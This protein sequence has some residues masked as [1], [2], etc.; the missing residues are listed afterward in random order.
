MLPGM[1]TSG[2]FFFSLEFSWSFEDKKIHVN[3]LKTAFCE[4]SITRLHFYSKC[5]IN[6]IVFHYKYIYDP[7]T[8]DPSRLIIFQEERQP[9]FI[10]DTFHACWIFNS[11]FLKL[12]L[13]QWIW[14]NMILTLIIWTNYWKNDEIQMMT[15]QFTVCSLN[16][17][18]NFH[19]HRFNCVTEYP[20]SGGIH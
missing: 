10:M 3:N 5:R 18:F 13:K 8:F 12:L 9:F 20:S 7:N 17:I 19:S 4:N 6:F 11:E 15:T 16:F 14:V 2:S 1:M